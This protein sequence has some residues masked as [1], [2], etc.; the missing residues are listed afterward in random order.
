MI[1]GYAINHA[2]RSWAFDDSNAPDRC[3]N[4]DLFGCTLFDELAFFSIRRA[5][6]QI[7]SSCLSHSTDFFQPI[8]LPQSSLSS[9]VRNISKMKWVFFLLCFLSV[10][11]VVSLTRGQCVE[12]PTSKS[13]LR[14]IFGKPAP[15]SLFP[16]F[17]LFS[18]SNVSG[19]SLYSFE[20]RSQSVLH[21]LTL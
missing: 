16:P 6:Y 14:H 7:M 17:I 1:V 8:N 19:D 10:L 20:T 4:S 3:R 11:A 2:F 5:D 9:G 21:F 13:T 18:S 15:H 12:V